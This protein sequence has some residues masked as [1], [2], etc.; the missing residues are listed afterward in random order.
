MNAVSRRCLV[1]LAVFG[2]VLSALPSYAAKVTWQGGVGVGWSDT[3]N[4]S[5]G[6]TPGSTAA[7]TAEFG[8]PSGVFQPTVDANQ[9][10]GS[11][12]ITKLTFLQS[13]WTLSGSSTLTLDAGNV[14]L[15][16]YVASSGS[17]TNVVA[18]PFRFGSGSAG[19]AGLGV[20]AGNTL[21]LAGG[22]TFTPSVRNVQ[23]TGA[24]TL[25]L[26][27]AVVAATFAMLRV[28]SVALETVVRQDRFDV[29]GKIQFLRGSFG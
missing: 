26:R 22:V 9:P 20:G 21:V 19:A 7:D 18:A 6:Y 28:G 16:E 3:G 5:T 13:G 24:G 29:A 12:R 2:S 4:W 10:T 23:R 15:G 27:G 25:V 17:G 11:G 8:S 14:T 1:R